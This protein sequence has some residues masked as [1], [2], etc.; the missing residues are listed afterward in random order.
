MYRVMHLRTA[1]LTL[2][3]LSI[4]NVDN[5]AAQP[6]QS[7]GRRTPRMKTPIID[8]DKEKTRFER[9]QWK[10]SQEEWIATRS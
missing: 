4:P 2:A 10:L 8:T 1:I 7:E 3:L 9:S 5:Y 6:L